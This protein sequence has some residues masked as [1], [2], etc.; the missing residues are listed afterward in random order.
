MSW[1]LPIWFWRTWVLFVEP[2][3]PLFWTSGDVSS[4]FQSQSGQP[5][6][7][8][9]EAYV[10]HIPWDSPAN[11]L[12]A[13]IVAEPSLPHTCK[14]LVGFETGS[15]SCHHSQREIRQARRSTN[16]AI[17]ANIAKFTNLTKKQNPLCIRLPRN[18]PPGGPLNLPPGS[19]PRPPHPLW[20]DRHV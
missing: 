16:W 11:L 17:A 1:T 2:L 12:V 10:L 4:G 20:T 14:A 18:T 6:S 19:G 3:I 5:Y 15:L 8:M 9:A 13:S 7:H